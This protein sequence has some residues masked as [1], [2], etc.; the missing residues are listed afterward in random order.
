MTE[1]TGPNLQ[2]LAYFGAREKIRTL[3][4]DKHRI[5]RDIKELKKFLRTGKHKLTDKVKKKLSPARLRALRKNIKKA[6]AAKKKYRLEREKN[7][8]K[9]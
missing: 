6:I 1:S 7:G 3:V 5:D 4:E 2:E 9:E 8:A